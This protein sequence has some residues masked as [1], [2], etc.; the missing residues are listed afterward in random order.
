MKPNKKNLTT[1]RR[2]LENKL[3]AWVKLTRDRT[4]PSGWIKAIRTSLGMST[5][6][7]AERLEVQQPAVV[8]LEER[9]KQGKVTLEL[10]ERAAQAMG[11]KLVYAI[12]PNNINSSIE[13]ILNERA[14]ALAKDMLNV[15]EHSMR[16]EA[17]GSETSEEQVESLAL[18]LKQKM[19]S[20]LWELSA[21]EKPKGHAG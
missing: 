6:Q 19:D 20:R 14:I 4:P 16:L 8:A 3:K 18:Q 11:C 1:Q 2:I 21:N 7:L 5:R 15:V 13:H 10:L 17:Q 12:V 9:E